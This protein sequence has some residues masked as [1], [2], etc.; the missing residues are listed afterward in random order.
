MSRG[1]EPPMPFDVARFMSHKFGGHGGQTEIDYHGGGQ[2]GEEQ[3]VP[4][5][6]SVTK[7]D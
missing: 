6:N 5:P 3:Q 7:E 1:Y 2:L 4:N